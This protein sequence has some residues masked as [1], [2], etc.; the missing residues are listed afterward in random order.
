MAE[1]NNPYSLEAA[2]PFVQPQ[3]H[4]TGN[5]LMGSSEARAVAEVKAQIFMAR[6]FPRD[7]QA[8]MERIITE[9]KRPT[10]AEKATYV[11]PRGKETVTGPSIRLAEAIA[12]GW[13]NLTFGYDVL[14]RSNGRSVISA[15]AWDLET[16]LRAS[17]QF[18]VQHWRQTKRGGY[19]LTDDRDIYELEANMAARR[20]RACIL[21]LIPGDVTDAA[22]DACKATTSGKIVM[23]MKDPEKRTATI[24][25]IIEL[26]DGLGVNESDMVDYLNVKSADWNADHIVKLHDVYNTLKDNAADIG[27]I[28]PRLSTLGDSD[29][30]TKEQVADIM[31]K[32][33]AIGKQRELSN[34]LKKQGISKVADIPASDLQSVN[35][36]LDGMMANA[37]DAQPAS[38]TESEG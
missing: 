5:T 18:E 21:Q 27:E 14:D 13:G 2:A 31:A 7:P 35:E 10:L 1:Y 32:A 24:K 36:Y 34:W 6:Q 37:H 12:R 4:D 29:T 22:L 19:K 33:A 38:D 16:N 8:A 9:C 11:F 25:R 30:I 28:F 3:S 23:A 15:Y 26:F 17:V 20:K